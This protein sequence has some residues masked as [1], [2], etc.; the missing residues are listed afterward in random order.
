MESKDH[1]KGTPP[2]ISHPSQ[3]NATSSEKKG[4]S[5]NKKNKDKEKAGGK[6]PTDDR[7]GKGN[8]SQN[9]STPDPGINI[10]RKIDFNPKQGEKQSVPENATSARTSSNNVNSKSEE[11]TIAV[12][13]AG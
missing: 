10:L 4:G 5:G 1:G 12:D 13:I 9:K 7:F 11:T 8:S 3:G 2:R 6:S